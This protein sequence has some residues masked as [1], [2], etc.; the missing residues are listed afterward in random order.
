ML[1]IA[2]SLALY[3][4]PNIDGPLIFTPIH[5]VSVFVYPW[6]TVLPALADERR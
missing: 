3:L 4:A 2:R 5:F 6:L 1:G